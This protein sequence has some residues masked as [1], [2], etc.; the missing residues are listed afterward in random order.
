MPDSDDNPARPQSG[1]QSTLLATPAPTPPTVTPTSALTSRVKPSWIAGGV[2]ALVLMI[3]VTA[4]VCGES[5]D[6]PKDSSPEAGASPAEVAERDEGS[7]EPAGDEDG[8]ADPADEPEGDDAEP[9]KTA[10]AHAS[11]A[12][13]SSVDALLEARKLDAAA[14]MLAPLLEAHPED[15]QLHWR[16]A[17]V[18]VAQGG[19]A[20]RGAALESYSAALASDATLI[21]DED[22][23]AELGTIFDDAKLRQAAVEL[24]LEHLGSQADDVLLEWLNVQSRPLD[25]RTR[26]RVIDH[27]EANERGGVI[28]RPLQR[29]LDLW[30]AQTLDDGV[31]KEF[32][33]ALDE[34][35]SEP[36]SY[37]TG[38]LLRVPVPL[39]AG[40]EGEQEA[41]P[42]AEQR[43]Q[44][45][46]NKY[47]DMYRGI[48][49]V[50]P[51]AFRSRRKKR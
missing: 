50:V 47:D 32:Q 43:L 24:A 5:D 42:E 14:I 46:R 48:D 51:K 34:A 7:D 19:Q 21:D 8:D 16:M 36:D 28:N 15:A 30:Q 44:E 6:E 31:C 38:T 10:S 49:P 9:T 2:G 39:A 29:A 40:A 45:A 12:T 41:C 25:Y 13:L 1:R 3:I 22:F 20:N 4:A 17:K 27:L 35:V 26:H 11:P 18:L 33:R 23:M 37:L